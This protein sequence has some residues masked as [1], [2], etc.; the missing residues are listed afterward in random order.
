MACFGCDLVKR[1]FALVGDGEQK[2]TE[3]PPF[4]ILQKE[5]Q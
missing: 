4:A 5:K 1:K 3:G 2:G